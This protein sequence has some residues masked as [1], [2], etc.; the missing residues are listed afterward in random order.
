VVLCGV[1]VAYGDND[2]EFRKN[3]CPQ[4]LSPYAAASWPGNTYCQSF[5]ASYGL[6]TA[7]PALFQRVWPSPGPDFTVRGGDSIFITAML[8][9]ERPTIYGDGSR[10]R[11]YLRRER[12]G[13]QICWRPSHRMPSARPMNIAT[14]DIDLLELMENSTPSWARRLYRCTMRRGPGDIVH[15]RA[16]NRK[17]PRELLDFGGRYVDFN[18]GLD[19]H[20]QVVSKRMIVVHVVKVTGIAGAE[21]HLLMLFAGLR[22]RD[23]DAR[24]ILLVE[25]DKPLD[26]YVQ[27]SKGAEFPLQR[28]VIRNDLDV[29]LGSG[30]WASPARESSPI[31]SHAFMATPTCFGIPAARLARVKT[32]VT[33]RHNDDAFRHRF[34]IR[35]VNRFCGDCPAPESPSRSDSPLLH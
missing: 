15:S 18:T 31:S 8:K 1:F 2:Y 5:T 25:P 7:L 12:G 3:R 33:S 6:E 9:G 32:I 29:T 16:S 30:A 4:P 24:L 35:L 26:D 13:R 34:A 27:C 22:A 20:R 10:P 14:A 21:R 23:V 17:K 11:F 19:T 28:L